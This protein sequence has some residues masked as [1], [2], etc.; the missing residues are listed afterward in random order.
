MPRDLSQRARFRLGGGGLGRL[1][2][3]YSTTVRQG[4]GVVYYNRLGY[5]RGMGRL[6]KGDAHYLKMLAALSE[7]RGGEELRI[8]RVQAGLTQADVAEWAGM[9]QQCLSNYEKGRRKPSEASRERVLKAIEG[10]RIPVV[11]DRYTAW[12]QEAGL[13]TSRLF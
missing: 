5:D 4:K 2:V 1:E 10:L 13:P 8:R 7:A 11:F 3:L 12:R 9:S 6:L